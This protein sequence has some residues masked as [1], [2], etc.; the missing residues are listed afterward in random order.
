MGRMFSNWK[1]TAAG[2]GTILLAVGGVLTGAV[3]LDQISVTDVLSLLGLGAVALTAKD[4][5]TGSAPSA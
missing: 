3:S 1:T 4:A 5:S 2:L